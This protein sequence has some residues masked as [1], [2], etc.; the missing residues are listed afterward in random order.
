MLL[1]CVLY[2]LF[3]WFIEL[4]DA[5]INIRKNSWALSCFK[6]KRFWLTLPPQQRLFKHQKH[7]IVLISHQKIINQPNFKYCGCTAF[8]PEQKIGVLLPFSCLN[9]EQSQL[10]DNIDILSSRRKSR[11]RYCSNSAVIKF[12]KIRNIKYSYGIII[13]LVETKPQLQSIL[14]YFFNGFEINQCNWPNYVTLFNLTSHTWRD[15][16][17]AFV[18]YSSRFSTN[19]LGLE[20]M[21]SKAILKQYSLPNINRISPISLVNQF[22]LRE[23]RLLSITGLQGFKF[24]LLQVRNIPKLSHWCLN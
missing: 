13:C 14:F 22:S 5:F 21:R 16:V 23:P 10:Q 12:T 20:L 8:F 19:Y 24:M 7:F 4:I 1:W 17:T 15:N 2:L 9:K 6:H 11:R 18:F 3:L